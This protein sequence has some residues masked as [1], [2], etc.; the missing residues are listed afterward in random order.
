MKTKAKKRL[1]CPA[2]RREEMVRLPGEGQRMR[3]GE[4]AAERKGSF[5]P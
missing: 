1:E 4:K 5:F 3:L 2:L